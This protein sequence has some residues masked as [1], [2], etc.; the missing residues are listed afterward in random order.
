MQRIRSTV[1]E[2]ARVIDG[3]GESSRQ[4]GTIVQTID[5]I[6]EQTNLLALNA[7]IE[8]ARAGEAGRGFAVVADE[9]RKL[10]E[11]SGAATREIGALIAEVQ[12]RTGEAVAAMEGGT[13]EVETGAALAEE[14]GS[15]LAQIQQAVATVTEGVQGIFAA[16]SEMSS[17]SEQVSRSIQEVAA[18]VEETSAAAQEMSASAEEV[19]ASVQ[20]VAA[21]TEQQTASLRGLV[22]S[23]EQM[24]GIAADLEAAVSRFRTEPATDETPEKT[25]LTLLKAA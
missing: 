15:A 13:R 11:R 19:S 7:A 10:A 1:A 9:V 23:A 2:S 12:A 17:T 24:S 14:A 5:A 6:A 25:P 4:I 8:A 16:A 20:T 22:T 21:T 3:L 18:V